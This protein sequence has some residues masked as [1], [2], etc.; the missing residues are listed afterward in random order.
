MPRCARCQGFLIQER[1]FGQAMRVFCLQCGREANATLP[2]NEQ[3]KSN[4]HRTAAQ[5]AAQRARNRLAREARMA[6]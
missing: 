5:L 1:E 3:P 4:R 2:I 6:K